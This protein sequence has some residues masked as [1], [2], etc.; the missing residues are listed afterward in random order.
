MNTKIWYLAAAALMVSLS[1]VQAGGLVKNLLNSVVSLN[2]GNQ[3]LVN[4]NIGGDNLVSVNTG[5]ALGNVAPAT[6]TVLGSG[7]V[8]DV[9][10]GV[11][12]IANVNANVGGGGG[13]GIGIGACVG[14]LGSGCS[15]GGTSPGGTDGGTGPGGAGP[16]GVGPGGVGPGGVV[17]VGIGSYGGFSVGTGNCSSADDQRA[18][19][20][21]T[22]G[23]YDMSVFSSWARAR[24]VDIIRVAPCPAV[25]KQ[26]AA[27]IKKTPELSMMQYAAA[28]DVLIAASLSRTSYDASNIL[29]VQPKGRNL[30]VFVY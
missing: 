22:S 10:V 20:L 16:G 3:A 7:G 6:V 2:G 25:K 4:A 15:G 12:G 18:I 1:P 24:S 19:G 23:R 26:L 17:S 5:G 28:S 29:A 14:L 11:A 27:V 30:Q 13:G 9:K 8:A 21:L